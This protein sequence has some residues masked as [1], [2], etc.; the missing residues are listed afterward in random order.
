MKPDTTEAMVRRE[1][2]KAVASLVA[3]AGPVKCGAREIVR[4]GELGQVAFCRVVD[5]EGDRERLLDFV[6]FVLDE[7]RPISVA[8]QTGR[9]TFRYRTFVASYERA[10]RESGVWFYGS[11]GTLRV[12]R[13][14]LGLWG[15]DGRMR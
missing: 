5:T 3:M 15:S 9:A 13:D 14:G 11:E 10:G 6:E 2:F 4:S 7:T 12:N 8:A 1:F